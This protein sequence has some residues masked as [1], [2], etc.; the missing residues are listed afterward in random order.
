VICNSASAQIDNGASVEADGVCANG[1]V[2]LELSKVVD[3]PTPCEDSTVTYTITVTNPGTANAT[4]VQVTDLLPTGLTYHS[5]VLSQ[6]G[7]NSATGLWT[8]GNVNTGASAT[9]NLTATVNNGTGG[10]LITNTG[11]ITHAEPTDSLITNN[12][13]YADIF[14][15][16][17]VASASSNSPVCEGSAI[18]LSG[19]PGGMTSYKWTGPNGFNST[20]QNP[21]IPN[22]TSPDAGTYYLT[23]TNGNCTGDPSSTVVTV[24]TK[25]TAMASSNSPVCEGGTIDLYGGPSGMTSYNWTGP[26]G[27]ASNDQNPIRTGATTAMAGTYTLTVTNSNGCTDDESTS[28]TV[29]AKPTA[30]ASSNSPVCEGGTIEL[31]GGPGGMTSYSWTG[32]N[33][34]SSDEQSP[35]V[36]TNAT[37]AMAGNYDLTVTDSNGCTATNLTTVTVNTKPTVDAGPDR[38]VC[39]D[40]DPITLSGATPSGGTWSGTGVSGNTFDPS[41]LTLADYTVTYSYTDTGTGCSNSDTK[42]VTV[43]ECCC[44]CGFVYR[45]GTTEP[46]AGWVVILDKETNSWDEVGRVT[47]G[48]DGKYCFCGLEYDVYRVSEVVQPG[49]NQVLPSSAEYLVTLPLGCCDPVSGPFLNF[50]N[51]QGPAGPL[52]VGWQVSP[53]DKLAVVAPWVTLFAVIVAGASLLVL[54][55]RRA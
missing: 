55:R 35:T 22:A 6:G 45:Y 17:S 26:G 44:I 24:N 1:G 29:N 27:W 28:V 52:T 10:Q 46:L 19:G 30:T 20:L 54:R 47:T 41:G 43:T 8:V 50:E 21:T 12:Y 51:Q 33:G 9:L 42:I 15:P 32:P 14:V 53:I 16:S 36:S 23:V 4:N 5:S 2:D 25:P 38:E 11:N 18:D 40:G 39:E 13:D 7:Y 31:Y 48:A 34:Y 3:R 37:L 49:W